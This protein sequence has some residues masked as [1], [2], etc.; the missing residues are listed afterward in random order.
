VS[1]KALSKENLAVLR[2]YNGYLRD[3]NRHGPKALKAHSQ[4]I[5]EVQRMEQALDL[6]VAS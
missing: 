1:P 4:I 3:L 2:L 6:G 5:A